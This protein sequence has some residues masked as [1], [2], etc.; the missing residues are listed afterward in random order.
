MSGWLFSTGWL[1]EVSVTSST[2]IINKLLSTTINLITLIQIQ[3]YHCKS[4][5]TLFYFILKSQVI[6]SLMYSYYL[7]YLTSFSYINYWISIGGWRRGAGG[8]RVPPIFRR[9]GSAPPN[10]YCLLL[11]LQKESKLILLVLMKLS[12]VKSTY[13]TW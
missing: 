6:A 3:D 5:S 12:K 9:G 11:T 10:F 8:A 4:S 1:K 13:H 7:P 2:L